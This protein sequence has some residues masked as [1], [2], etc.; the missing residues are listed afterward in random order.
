MASIEDSRGRELW[1]MT[2]EW[3]TLQEVDGL[4]EVGDADV[5]RERGV[6]ALEG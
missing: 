4:G 6:L 2:G 3:L 5:F 1:R